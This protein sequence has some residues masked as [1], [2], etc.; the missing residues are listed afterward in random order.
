MEQLEEYDWQELEVP[1]KGWRKY[2]GEGFDRMHARK[3]LVHP[4]WSAARVNTAANIGVV[5][6]VSWIGF[7][8]LLCTYPYVFPATDV[9]LLLGVGLWSLPAYFAGFLLLWACGDDSVTLSCRKK[10]L[11]KGIKPHAK[12]AE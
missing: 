10:L 2:F 7:V 6:S 8:V 9:D 4:G 5:V 12:E 1:Q 3:K 11:E